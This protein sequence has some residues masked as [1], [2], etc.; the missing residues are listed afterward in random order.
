MPI[1]EAVSA[2]LAKLK[3]RDRVLIE[4]VDAHNLMLDGWVS[5]DYLQE[6]DLNCTVRT[7]G[8]YILHGGD[9]VVIAG[10]YIV[11]EEGDLSQDFNSA[12]AV[13]LGCIKRIEVIGNG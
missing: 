6:L 9:F 13:P 8:Y 2:A 12:S 11:P 5:L 7:L 3:I 4:W 10:D 1:E